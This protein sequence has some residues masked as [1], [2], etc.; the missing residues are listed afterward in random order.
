MHLKALCDLNGVAYKHKDTIE[1]LAQALSSAQK[2][3][4]TELK[5][6]IYL[7]GIRNDCAHPNEVSKDQV[8]TLI[9]QVKKLSR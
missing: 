8:R 2:I 7:G 4:L 9:E 3:E 5:K 1:P 6:F